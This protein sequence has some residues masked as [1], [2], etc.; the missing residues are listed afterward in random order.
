MVG[1]FFVWHV[2]PAGPECKP[3]HPPK[4]RLASYWLDSPLGQDSH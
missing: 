1:A 2:Y 4:L 3:I